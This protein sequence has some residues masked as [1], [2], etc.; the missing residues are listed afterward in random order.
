MWLQGVDLPDERQM[1]VWAICDLDVPTA[2][3][4][5]AGT[6]KWRVNPHRVL[7]RAQYDQSAADL[8]SLIYQERLQGRTGA[9]QLIIPKG[10]RNLG[11]LPTEGGQVVLR[12]DAN[13]L[14]VWTEKAFRIYLAS[15][16]IHWD[17][18]ED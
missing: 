7:S 12:S 11:W 17:D 10:I 9:W 3:D 5:T 18:T 16:A 15:L 6:L 13:G 4:A 8:A 2:G 14:S 1:E